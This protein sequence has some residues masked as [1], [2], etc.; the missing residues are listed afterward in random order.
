MPVFA[1]ASGALA[2][3]FVGAVAVW[4]VGSGAPAGSLIE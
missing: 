3:A 1:R 2:G 4:T